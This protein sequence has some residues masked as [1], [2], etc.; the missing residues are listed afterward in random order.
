[1]AYLDG[2]QSRYFRGAS[3]GSKAWVQSIDVEAEVDRTGAHLG[4]DLRHQRG[5]GPKPALLRR[6]HAEAL[7]GRI[8]SLFR[9]S[10][11]AVM[12][13]SSIKSNQSRFCLPQ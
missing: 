1:M 4:P 3:A 9:T 12:L 5:Q 7:R 13:V 10:N 11:A 8:P 2:S 6:N